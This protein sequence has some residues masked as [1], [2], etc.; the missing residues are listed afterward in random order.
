VQPYETAELSGNL[1]SAGEETAAPEVSLG[2]ALSGWHRIFVGVYPDHRGL[3]SIEL[4]LS[5]DPCFTHLNMGPEWSE[6]SPHGHNIYELFWKDADLTGQEMFVRQVCTPTGASDE[7]AAVA[8]QRTKIAYVKMLPL[9]DDQVRKM[10]SERQRTDTRRLFAHN[11]A[12]GYLY[13]YGT[14]TEEAV[15][16]EIEPYRHTDFSRLYWECGAGD[17][18]F[19]LGQ[20]GRLPTCDGTEDFDRQGDRLQ[21][22]PQPLSVMVETMWMLTQALML[23][24]ARQPARTPLLQWTPARQPRVPQRLTPAQSWRLLTRA[25]LVT[26]SLPP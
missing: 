14:A 15:R 25:L 18:M 21:A 23:T 24:K 3:G 20:V 12:H 8:C 4:K 17:S 5:G 9:P 1:L 6:S 11:D 19:Y 10:E 2:L 16:N 13:L 22:T 7:P 26:R